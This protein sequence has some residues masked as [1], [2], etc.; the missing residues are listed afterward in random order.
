MLVAKGI[1]VM[2]KQ[3][4]CCS[5]SFIGDKE[6]E[7]CPECRE[8]QPVFLVTVRYKEYYGQDDYG[9]IYT[10]K[11]IEETVVGLEALENLLI[12][13]GEEGHDILEQKQVY[14]I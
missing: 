8:E 1:M 4:D 9:S 13:C 7:V 5:N 3:C 2:E 12:S 10:G 11:T 14:Y 6:T